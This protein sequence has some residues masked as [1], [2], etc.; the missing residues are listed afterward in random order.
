[1]ESGPERWRREALGWDSSPAWRSAAMLYPGSHSCPPRQRFPPTPRCF[2]GCRGAPAHP[3]ATLLQPRLGEGEKSRLGEGGQSGAAR[4]AAGS[5]T[6]GI[7]PQQKPKSPVQRL[8]SS[9][10]LPRPTPVPKGFLLLAIPALPALSL[11]ASHPDS[12][13]WAGRNVNRLRAARARHHHPWCAMETLPGAG[14]CPAAPSVPIPAGCGSPLPSLWVP[15]LPELEIPGVR[16][17]RSCGREQKSRRE[18]K[19][20]LR[21]LR[22]LR[23][24]SLPPAGAAA[25]HGCR[26]GAH[27]RAMAGCCGDPVVTRAKV[28]WYQAPSWGPH[29]LGAVDTGPPRT[30]LTAPRET[31][32]GRK[33]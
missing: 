22:W 33:R 16:A 30:F 5:G 12:A 24:A 32:R 3:A 21:G 10:S 25:G 17:R 29:G 8:F 19:A 28:L 23:E 9:P 11:S 18:P 31:G 2:P 15:W 4:L 7:S 1:M 13:G 6:I 26:C 20:P 14:V 27:A